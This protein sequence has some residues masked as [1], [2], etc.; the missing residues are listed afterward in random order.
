MRP[1]PCSRLLRL[2]LPELHRPGLREGLG[3]NLG[4]HPTVNVF[5]DLMSHHM[6][7]RR[8]DV[9]EGRVVR[10]RPSAKLEKNRIEPLIYTNLH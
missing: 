7:H 6:D 8:G 9:L 4:E 2:A 5:R 1:P 3:E 10:G